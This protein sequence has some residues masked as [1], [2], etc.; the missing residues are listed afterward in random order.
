MP[1]RFRCKHCNQLLGIA[2]RKIGMEVHCPECHKRVRVPAEDAPEG[3]E[4]TRKKGPWFDSRDLDSQL[5]PSVAEPAAKPL[6][7]APPPA[8]FPARPPVPP[9]DVELYN[10][11]P[12]P[13]AVGLVVSPLQAALLTLG[14][15]LVLAVA[16]AMGVLV[17]RF[18]S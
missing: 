15:V 1:V 13:P 4:P 9:L 12:A 3:H 7:P 17:G 18:L 10:P 11:S 6:K 2:R 14:A 16:F 5:Q 8:W